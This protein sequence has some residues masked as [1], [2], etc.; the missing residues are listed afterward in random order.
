MIHC[1]Q[2]VVLGEHRQMRPGQDVDYL[3]YFPTHIGPLGILLQHYVVIIVIDKKCPF[4]QIK[5]VKTRQNNLHSTH[6]QAGRARNLGGRM[7]I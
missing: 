1:V 4:Q 7:S 3:S 5:N 2:R 6:S